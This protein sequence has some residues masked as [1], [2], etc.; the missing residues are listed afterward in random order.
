MTL[1]IWSSK[2]V[3][4]FSDILKTA[5][6]IPVYKKGDPSECNHYHP[7]SILSALGKLI[8]KLIHVTLNIFLELNN[9]FY[10]NQFGFRNY[11][12]TNHALITTTE[13]I[14]HALDNDHYMC[15]I[16]VDFQKAFDKVNH[17]ILLSK[18]YYYG[19]RDTPF[20]LI[21]SYFTNRKQ[22]THINDSESTALISTH[23]V[24]KGSVLGPLL[25]FIYIYQ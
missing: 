5:K 4:T 20:K 6:I 19:I 8:E 1:Q 7:I 9:C 2:Q 16:F 22:Y 11:H 3:Y 10:E 17:D 14:R 12:S 21:K 25:F 13:K 18:L 23:G 24:P 15:G